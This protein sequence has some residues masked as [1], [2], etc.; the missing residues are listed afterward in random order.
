MEQIVELNSTADVAQANQTVQFLTEQSSN[1][2]RDIG[3]LEQQISGI[4]LRFGGILSRSNAPVLGGGSA[5]YDIQ[6]A[7][8]TRANQALQMQKQD[9][10]T[11]STR[12]PVVAQAEAGLAAA[13]AVYAD[14]HP[15]VKIARQR[16]EEAK[17]LAKQNVKKL[18]AENLDQQIAF[19]N[20]QL[21]TLRAAKARESAQVSATLS[22]QSQ[23]PAVQQTTAQLQQKLD[24][25]YKQY[26][27]VSERLM[28]A[29]AGARAANEQLGERLVVVDPPVVPD[30]PAS[31]NR[32]LILG[33]GIGAGLVLGLLLGLGVEM[34]LQ[35][36]RT[37]GRI[38]QLTGA[39]TLAMVP[40]IVPRS[41]P[42]ETGRRWMRNPFRRHAREEQAA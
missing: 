15:D 6:I 1:L 25:L 29:Q 14:D 19:N 12:D 9:L 10:G 3:A 37:P 41:A 16:L 39:P 11:A 23:A 8:L 35:P 5:S 20:S 18:P 24:T 7:E 21:A 17:Q 34:F 32:L 40:V 4:N 28:T 2:K 31:P 22:S 36:I 42:R 38:A 30:E 13:R 26:D 27:A 33:G